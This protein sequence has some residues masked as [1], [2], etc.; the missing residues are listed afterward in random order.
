MVAGGI[1]MNVIILATF[2]T[3]GIAMII[4]TIFIGRLYDYELQ[5]YRKWGWTKLATKW[6]AR[7]KWWLP[8]CRACCLVIAVISFVIVYWAL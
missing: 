2:V 1:D 8:I 4:V 5:L 6:G 7:K 3:L